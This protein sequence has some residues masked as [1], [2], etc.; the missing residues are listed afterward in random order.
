[1]TDAVLTARVVAFAAPAALSTT[2]D[3]ARTVL[4]HLTDQADAGLVAEETLAMVA[5]VTARA[6]EVGLR[7]R[8]AVLAAVGPALAEVPYLYHDFLLGAQVVAAGGEGDVEPDQSV[9]ERLDRKLAFYTAHLAPGR[10]PGP[11]LLRE[12]LPLWMGRVS[13]PKLPT[14]PD[15]RLAETG[16]VDLVAA[17]ARLVMAFAQKAAESES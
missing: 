17:H 12:K 1:M 11:S 6:A 7:Q 9:Y 5:T 10:F 2:Q 14:S 8:P 13:P 15:A 4:P 16:V 3:V